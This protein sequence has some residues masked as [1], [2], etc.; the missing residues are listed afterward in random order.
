MIFFFNLQEKYEAF[1]EGIVRGQYADNIGITSQ[2]HPSIVEV[3][4]YIYRIFKLKIV[5]FE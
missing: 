4:G 3:Y 2:N 5:R 1:K